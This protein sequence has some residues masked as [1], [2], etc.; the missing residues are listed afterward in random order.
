MVGS[1]DL[2][3]HLLNPSVVDLE[4][5][6]SSVLFVQDL[7]LLLTCQIFFLHEV[8]MGLYS[9]KMAMPIQF[10]LQFYA[11]K[12]CTVTLLFKLSKTFTWE[13]HCTKDE[14][15]LQT[16]IPQVEMFLKLCI[17]PELLEGG[18]LEAMAVKYPVMLL[19]NSTWRRIAEHG[20]TVN[21][22]RCWHDLLWRQWL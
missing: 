22:Q 2:L 15:L 3:M 9:S 17:L 18:S 6:R 12:G 11:T 1:T 4:F 13:H 19:M 8:R 21:S 7:L 10:L 14:A 16:I 5:W 20:A